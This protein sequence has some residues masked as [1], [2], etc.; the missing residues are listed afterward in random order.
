MQS[1][2]SLSVGILQFY[3]LMCSH[4]REFFLLRV[5]L[6]QLENALLQKGNL[7]CSTI[8]ISENAT[9]ITLL[10]DDG[11]LVLLQET[12]VSGFSFLKQ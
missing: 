10:Q 7:A 2:P 9:P 8:T 1:C 5:C 6:R 3:Q 12:G 4:F 11:S